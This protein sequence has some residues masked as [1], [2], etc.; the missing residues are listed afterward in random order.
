MNEAPASKEQLPH[1]LITDHQVNGL[2]EKIQV[3]AVDDPGAGGANHRYA[4]TLN[5]TPEAPSNRLLIIEFQNGPIASPADMNG[6]TNEAL[7]AVLIDRMRGFQ[8]IRH[9][10]GTFDFASSGKFA[11]RENA[12]ALLHLEESL[13]WLKRRTEGRM[14]R[15]VEGSHTA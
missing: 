11:C 3:A 10:D 13:M 5:T 6:F 12:T 1:R 14:Q 7:L 4:L 8:H 15:G 9:L 2:N